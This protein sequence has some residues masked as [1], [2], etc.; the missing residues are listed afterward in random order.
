MAGTI[1]HFSDKLERLEDMMKTE[2]GQQMARVRTER[3]KMFREWWREE[4]KE[5]GFLD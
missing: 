2:M 1:E 3:L 5:A 4:N